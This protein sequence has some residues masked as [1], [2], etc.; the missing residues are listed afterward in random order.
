VAGREPADLVRALPEL[1]PRTRIPGSVR[2]NEARR[3]WNEQRK[4]ER[5]AAIRY[6]A[7]LGMSIRALAT[8]HH[9][10]SPLILTA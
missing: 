8:K 10:V 2:E 7:R 5:F 1:A 4:R 9:V 3:A 6:D